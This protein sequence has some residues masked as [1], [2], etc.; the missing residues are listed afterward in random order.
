MNYTA[1]A[2]AF[3]GGGAAFITFIADMAYRDFAGGASPILGY[4]TIG[5][6]VIC[7]IGTIKWMLTSTS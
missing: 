2:M 6:L 3:I 5:F 4:M 1:K 7:I